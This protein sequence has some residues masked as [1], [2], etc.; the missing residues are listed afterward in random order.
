MIKAVASVYFNFLF[1]LVGTS[2]KAAADTKGE[3]TAANLPVKT[4]SWR[5]TAA[6]PC[7]KTAHLEQPASSLFRCDNDASHF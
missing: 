5:L 4:L 6:L 1:I 7:K 2:V 3:T